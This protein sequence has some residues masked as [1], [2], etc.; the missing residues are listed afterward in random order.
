MRLPGSKNTKRH[1]DY[2]P[3]EIVAEHSS[4]LSYTLDSF[5]KEMFQALSEDEI[6]RGQKHLDR[7]DGKLTINI[8]GNTDLGE[9][10]IA[11]GYAY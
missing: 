3:A 8:C 7:L 4:G 9:L 1:G 5:P 10:L 11:D 6:K 2:V